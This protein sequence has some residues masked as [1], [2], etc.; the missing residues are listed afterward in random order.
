MLFS[1]IATQ[2]G[3]IACYR[4]FSLIHTPHTT[5]TDR[6]AQRTIRLFIPFALIIS[7]ATYMSISSFL[8]PT[9]VS[10]RAR[11][12]LA[13]LRCLWSF[14]P[15]GKRT[16]RSEAF[17]LGICYIF[18]FAMFASRNKIALCAV[19]GCHGQINPDR[20]VHCARRREQ[21][22]ICS[23]SRPDLFCEMWKCVYFICTEHAL[24]LQHQLKHWP[25]RLISYRLC[26]FC[27]HR[28]STQH[29]FVATKQ[30]S[31]RRD[32]NYDWFECE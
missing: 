17:F 6:Y 10:N 4:C 25:D 26:L 13:H 29:I 5:H 31:R 22:D 9:I 27:R 3:S 30:N 21:N 1:R 23:F 15:F 24:V 19:V 8:W 12:C 28:D 18:V 32:I 14:C 2:C 7:K 11:S 20:C 16:D